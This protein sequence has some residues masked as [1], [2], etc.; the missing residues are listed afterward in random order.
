MGALNR[1]LARHGSRVLPWLAMAVALACFAT[2]L[3][4]WLR[5]SDARAFN[6]ER[7][8]GR[9]A[10]AVLPGDAADRQYLAA[11]WMARSGKPDQALQYLSQAGTSSDQGLRAAVRFAIG[12]RYF[13]MAVGLADVS[14]G[15]GHIEAVAQ[16]ELA[17]EA[18]RQA[19]RI[20]PELVGARYNLELLDRI[21]PPRRLEGWERPVDGATL[22]SQKRDGW[23]SMKDNVR[24]GLP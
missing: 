1:W 2:S 17:R 5:W 3:W 15:R 21:S 19:L 16:I 22:V 13:D 9:P 12:N 4:W 10:H 11:W 14:S 7:A 6:R 18:Y 23:A 8:E 20:D 24:R